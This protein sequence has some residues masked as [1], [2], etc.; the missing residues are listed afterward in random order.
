MSKQTKYAMTIVDT[1]SVWDVTDRKN[2]KAVAHDIVQVPDTIEEAEDQGFSGLGDKYELGDY[3][4]QDTGA[5]CKISYDDLEQ[6]T[7]IEDTHDEESVRR[8]FE[9]HE[10]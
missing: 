7:L 3:I 1:M 8:Y 6:A 9:K 10:E 2:P 5:I 4:D